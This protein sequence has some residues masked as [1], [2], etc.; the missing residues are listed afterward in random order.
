MTEINGCLSSSL[1]SLRGSVNVSATVTVSCPLGSD[2][3]VTISVGA[4]PVIGSITVTNTSFTF[5]KDVS[6]A[7]RSVV[8]SGT[9]S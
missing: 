5:G 3:D 4:S 6:V 2:C 7:L 1:N 9:M 8:T